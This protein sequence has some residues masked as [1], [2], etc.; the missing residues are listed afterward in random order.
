MEIMFLMKS[1]VDEHVTH[2]ANNTLETRGET[3]IPVTRLLARNYGSS[4][5]SPK[6]RVIGL[7]L[8]AVTSI[9]RTSMQCALQCMYACSKLYTFP[10]GTV[11]LQ[12]RTPRKCAQGILNA[13]STVQYSHSVCCCLM[14]MS[15]ARAQSFD[16]RKS[17][18][19]QCGVQPNPLPS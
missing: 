7:I 1:A 18:C 11:L 17:Q 6:I 13:Y 9:V 16:F 19:T 15:S 10:Y 12:S 4:D 2:L 8:N 14:P 3:S 5:Y